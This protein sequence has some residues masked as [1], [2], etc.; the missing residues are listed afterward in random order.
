MALLPLPVG[1]RLGS[2]EL[3]SAAILS[4]MESVSDVGFRRVCHSHCGAAFTWTEMV[5]ASAL[6]RGNAATL[7][8]VDTYDDTP[9][10]LQLLAKN[11]TE[12]M[13]A[14]RRLEELHSSGC[15]PHL[16]HIAAVDVNFGCPSPDV[17]RIGA[18]PALLKRR[19][20]LR[21]IFEALVMWRS[22]SVLSNVSAVGCKI[23]LGLNKTEADM[24]VYLPLV[25]AANEAGLDYIT[26]H[27]R[28]AAQ[29][30]SDLPTWSAIGEVKE[31]ARPGLSV[32]G[33]GVRFLART[34]CWTHIASIGGGLCVLRRCYE[35]EPER[36]APD[37][38]LDSRL[39]LQNIFSAADAAEM[40]RLTNCDGFMLARAAISNPWVSAPFCQAV[41]HR[42]TTEPIWERRS[43]GN[44]R[45]V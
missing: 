12:I 6:S 22:S 9:T 13:G 27:A 44:L 8:L 16:R 21:Q 18:G 10:G 15:M 2:L 4:P 23:R 28:H 30:S 31:R 14:L 19:A 42:H 17:I 25:D 24:K 36:A 43:S 34:G 29:R 26:V 33:N 11:E 3:R 38:L 35:T 40:R 5:R 7:D 45:G 32:I 39:S 1:L 37:E 20:K 41:A